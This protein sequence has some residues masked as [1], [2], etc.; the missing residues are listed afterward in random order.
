ML[1]N[2]PANESI[3]IVSV[4]RDYAMY[5]MRIAHNPFANSHVLQAIDNRT[6]NEHISTHY[7]HFLES[8]NYAIPAWFIFCHEDFEIKQA[9]GP[10][11]GALDK[12]ALYGPIGA[13][14]SPRYFGLF[15]AW[16]LLGQITES[17]KDGSNPRF[18]GKPVPAGT[19]IETFDCQCLII[20]SELIRTTGLRFDDHLSFDLYIE[21]FCMQAKESFNI[22]S[23]ILPLVCQ[24]WS[25]GKVS[26]RYYQ[27]E[28][29]VNAKYP[30]CCYTGTSSYS[31]G[32]PPLLRRFNDHFKRFLL[33]FVRS[34]KAINH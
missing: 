12:T 20:H 2:L 17:N 34:V 3:V 4:V 15:Y 13:K 26:E 16:Q 32:N 8:Y 6:V 30:N 22:P 1:A 24:H 19:L 11:F 10:L 21:D 23:R 5:N 14:T 28:K 18:I 29:Y 25:G 27:Q 31:L 7:N 9:L 33:K